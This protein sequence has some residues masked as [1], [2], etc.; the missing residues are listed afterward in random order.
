MFQAQK[1]DLKKS[2]GILNEALNRNKEKIDLPSEFIYKNKTI[3]DAIEI[4]NSFNEYFANIGPNLSKKIDPPVNST[5]TYKSY[6]TDPTDF[7]FQFRRISEL[8][9]RT[10]IDNLENKTSCGCDGISNKLL[11]LIKNEISKPI[12]LIVNQS[13]KTGI[14]PKAF[15]IAKVKPIYKKG[16]KADLNNYRPIS[17]LPT[18]SKIFERVIHTQ[19]YK[20]LSDNK[21]LC[22]QQ[23]GFRSQHSTELAAIKLVDYLTHN[24]DTNNIPISIYL[25]LSKAFDTL[26]FDIL[27]AKFEYYGITG[28]TLKLLTSYLKDRYQYV[29]YN[30]ET[31]NMLEIR[32]GIPQGSILGPLFFSICINDI[33][34][35]SAIFNYIMYADDTTLYCNLE[36]FVDCDTETAINRE[37]QKINLWLQRNKLTLNVEKTK[38][39]IFHKCKKVP[40]LSIALNDTTITKVD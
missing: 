10:A 29:I 33:V 37:L 38:F 21:L 40:N 31:S 36:D 12:T 23:Y 26:S 22:E 11:K 3:T 2:W 13:L 1:T 34:K 9:V 39:M 16:D 35:A 6:L 7:R 19:L 30:G 15:K 4:A 8:E 18:I 20:Y 27:L 14:F 24:I 17:L 25:D 32:T 5:T 28:T